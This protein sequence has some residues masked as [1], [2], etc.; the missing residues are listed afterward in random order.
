[1][2][3]ILCYGTNDDLIDLMSDEAKQYEIPDVLFKYF[4]FCLNVS[5]LRTNLTKCLT[6]STEIRAEPFLESYVIYNLHVCRTG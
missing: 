2:E 3:C 1:M 6:V 5:I 4:S